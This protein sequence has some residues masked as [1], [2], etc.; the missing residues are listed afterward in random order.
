MANKSYK[1]FELRPGDSVMLSSHTIPGNEKAVIDMIN[2]L[3][4]IGLEIMDDSSLDIHSSGHGY[5]EDIKMMMAML[6][7][8]YYMPVHGEIFMRHANEKIALSMNIPQEN[9]LIPFNG[10]IV[11]LYD[12]IVLVSE[13]KIKLDTIMIDGKGQ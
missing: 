10:Q 12:D 3:V 8:E 1:D 11:E 4:A 6:K 7:P 13:K 5:Q 9:I 2:D